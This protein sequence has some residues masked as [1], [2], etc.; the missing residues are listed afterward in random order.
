MKKCQLLSLLLTLICIQPAFAA[1]CEFT[2]AGD[3][4]TFSDPENWECGCDC[5]DKIPDL[6]DEAIIDGFAVTL[7]I[8]TRVKTFNLKAGSLSAFV[9]EILET[10]EMIWAGGE[11]DANVT[12]LPGGSLAMLTPATKTLSKKLIIESGAIGTWDAGTFGIGIFGELFIVGDLMP[13]EF[14][15]SFDGSI[16]KVDGFLGKIVNGGSFVKVGGLGTLTIDAIVENAGV[17][18]VDMGT[19]KMADR[20]INFGD[21][22]L[23]LT[24]SVIELAK[25]SGHSEMGVFAGMGKMI[26]KG[27]GPHDIGRDYDGTIDFEFDTDVASIEG[28]VTTS[29]TVDFKHGFI[30]GPA[31]AELIVS[32]TMNW[33]EGTLD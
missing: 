12:V 25:S 5:P 14:G 26:F 6:G 16:S 15:V 11:V 21:I 18:R 7:D 33:L 8:T 20:C 23:P 3:G 4:T 19:L 28:V 22:V 24:S 31:G 30:G 2:G 29:G 10:E 27:T 1:L 13:G 32:G 17:I 9:G